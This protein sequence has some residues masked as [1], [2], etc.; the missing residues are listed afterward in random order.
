MLCAD[1]LDKQAWGKTMTTKS[2][3][4]VSG[5]KTGGADIFGTCFA[6]INLRKRMALG[7]ASSSSAAGV[8]GTEY[9]SGR[10]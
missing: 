6:P 7:R 5:Q 2:S 1:E 4:Q 3:E 8:N 9:R 10:M